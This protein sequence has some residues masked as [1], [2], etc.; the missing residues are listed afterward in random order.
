MSMPDPDKLLQVLTRVKEI[1]IEA[2]EKPSSIQK[3]LS[4]LA[5]IYASLERII[6]SGEKPNFLSLIFTLKDAPATLQSLQRKA[7][8][9]PDAAAILMQMNQDI[10]EEMKPIMDDLGGMLPGGFNFP[11]M[12]DLGDFGRQADDD[13]FPPKPTKPTPPK[14][15]PGKPPKSGDFDL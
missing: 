14:G 15:N 4:K 7:S 13:L 9:D 1:V 12:G 11:G 5:G 10:Q 2:S 8:A 6:S 3:E